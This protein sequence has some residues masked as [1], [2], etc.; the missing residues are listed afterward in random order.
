[1]R[2]LPVAIAAVIV[3]SA[4]PARACGVAVSP[5]G[6][7]S[8]SDPPQGFFFVAGGIATQ[9][10]TALDARTTTPYY[11]AGVGGVVGSRYG[12]HFAPM[13]EVI[14]RGRAIVATS[15]DVA[16][17]MR[18]AS[19]GFV[20]GRFGVAIE[21]G[22]WTRVSGGRAL[23]SLAAMTLGAPAGLHASWMVQ[24]GSHGERGS[25]VVVGFDFLR[26]AAGL[27]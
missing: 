12:V 16:V 23:G 26:A 15:T 1:M 24:Q 14:G 25:A 22:A 2:L 6:G 3:C 27:R 20:D 10:P 4:N 17:A 19:D 7:G 5:F 8:Y 13:V 9:R 18:L 21:G 11:V